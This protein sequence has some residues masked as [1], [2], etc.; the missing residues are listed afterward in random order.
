M[1][2]KRKINHDEEGDLVDSMNRIKMK[3]QIDTKTPLE[4]KQWY[5]LQQSKPIESTDLVDR[6]TYLM[7]GGKPSTNID[8]MI[9]NELNK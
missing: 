9:L 3:Q 6:A 7:Y 2:P 5:K 4:W 8:R 1:P